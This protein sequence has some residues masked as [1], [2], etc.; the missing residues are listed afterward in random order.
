MHLACMHGC[1]P[2]MHD[3]DALFYAGR[4]YTF[5]L[6]SQASLAPAVTMY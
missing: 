3:A 5:A 2:S 4:S 1:M 6:L